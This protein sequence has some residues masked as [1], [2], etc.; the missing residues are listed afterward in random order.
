ME[1]ETTGRYLIFNVHFLITSAQR[2]YEIYHT[3]ALKT[4]FALNGNQSGSRLGK[5]HYIEL[6]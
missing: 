4:T 3:I 5:K 2:A 1:A 6:F